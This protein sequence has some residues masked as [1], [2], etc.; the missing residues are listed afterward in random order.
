MRII[1]AILEA[2][3]IMKDGRVDIKSF[4]VL[5]AVG[6]YAAYGL[7]LLSAFFILILIGPKVTDEIMERLQISSRRAT[8]LEAKIA[9][10]KKYID[11]RE[12]YLQGNLNELRKTMSR[13]S[14]KIIGRDVTNEP[15]MK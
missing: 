1:I 12:K 4:F 9:D 13:V 6:I 14:F 15:G 2:F 10:L 8:H 5:C 7:D 11:D 3:H